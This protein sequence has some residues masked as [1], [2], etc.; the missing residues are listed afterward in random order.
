MIWRFGCN[1]IC[2]VDS[3]K[4]DQEAKLPESV[5]SGLK[6][7]GLFGQQVPEEFGGLGLNATEYARIAEVVAKDGA[8][9]VTLAAHQAIGLKV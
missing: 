2:L 5:L 1:L 6:A 9:G 7:L 3:K 4:I 8:I